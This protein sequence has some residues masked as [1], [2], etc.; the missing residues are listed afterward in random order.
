MNTQNPSNDYLT[1]E[2]HSLN[3]NLFLFLLTPN[4]AT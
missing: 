1:L 4:I 3:S 2:L